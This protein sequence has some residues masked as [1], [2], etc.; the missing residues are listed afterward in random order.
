[1]TKRGLGALIAAL[2][3]TLTVI[4]V[5][6][7]GMTH[8][9]Q[10]TLEL[11]ASSESTL[12]VRNLAGR[13]A[14]VRLVFIGDRRIQVSRNVGPGGL[15]RVDLGGPSGE[16]I[17]VI[18]DAGEWVLSPG[19]KRIVTNRLTSQAALVVL[20]VW[21][22]F[23]PLVVFLWEYFRG[24]RGVA[25]PYLLAYAPT[26]ASCLHAGG[27]WAAFSPLVSSLAGSASAL[28]LSEYA[29]RRLVVEE[30]AREG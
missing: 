24:V 27:A 3:Y 11:D 4:H 5:T 19:G 15:L 25:V 30:G 26:A 17:L 18:T 9:G 2:A 16:R 23:P 29:R 14:I 1:V 12:V 13:S 21:T 28:L 20:S 8:F 6:W 10:V 22:L 7:A